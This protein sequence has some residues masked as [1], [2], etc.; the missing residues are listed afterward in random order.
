MRVL[1]LVLLGI[2]APAVAQPSGETLQMSIPS[3]HKQLR[4][5]RDG[6]LSTTEWRNANGQEHLMLT[7]ARGSE[8]ESPTAQRDGMASNPL[9]LC[10]VKPIREGLDNG[11]RYALWAASCQD[12]NAAGRRREIWS[13]AIQGRE[14]LYTVRKIFA[15]P[16][17]DKDIAKW[18]AYLDAVQ[19][20]DPQLPNSPC[21]R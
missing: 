16:P 13:K 14:A 1:L 19:V 4:D 7:I 15:R 11:Y 17:A 21:R 20:C 10:T 18:I 12:T 8:I 9:M 6:D 3:D 5:Q 2:A